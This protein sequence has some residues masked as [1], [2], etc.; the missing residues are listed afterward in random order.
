MQYGDL[1]IY[2]KLSLTTNSHV[3]KHMLCG[4]R[5]PLEYK[6]QP[7]VL[8][9]HSLLISGAVDVSMCACLHVYSDVPARAAQCWL[10]FMSHASLMRLYSK[11]SNEEKG[12]C[13]SDGDPV[14]LTLRLMS[15]CYHPSPEL[16]CQHSVAAHKV[17]AA[18]VIICRHHYKW[19]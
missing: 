4:V 13:S 19:K 7:V 14:S 11:K 6:K 1:C 2:T 3:G 12:G 10:L 15:G 16:E 8:S 18:C 9:L 17:S 5:P